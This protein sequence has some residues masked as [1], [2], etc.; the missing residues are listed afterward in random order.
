M[1]IPTEDASVPAPLVEVQR[2]R[3]AWPAPVAYYLVTVFVLI[4]LNFALPRLMPGDAIDG[5]MVSGSPN[6]V[7][8]DETR[9]RLAEY[10]NLDGS[11]LEQYR[12]YLGALAGGD[13]G[14]SIYSNQPVTQ[15]LGDRMGWS[16]L[17]IVTALVASV[18]VGLPLGVHSAWK[19]SRPVDRRLLTFFLTIQNTPVFVVG[20][21]VLNLFSARLGLFPYGGA[22]TYFTDYSGLR[23][24]LDIAHHLALPALVMALDFVAYQ[25]L[26]MRSAMVMELGSDYLLVGRAK[27]LRQR[28]LKYGYAGRNALLPIVTVIGIQLGLSIT[29][30]VFVEGI[31]N[32]PGI[33]GYLVLA[34][35]RRDY[36]A[37]QGAFLILSL[38]VVTANLF[39]DLLYRR[40]D[41]RT[42]A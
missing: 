42:S 33:G 5:L 1:A 39:V 24:V 37:A 40:L 6:F 2:P 14:V 13:L 34:V 12:R 4:T 19:R 10:L 41:P 31:F 35:G 17:L 18:L 15:E 38:M 28:R 11:M 9:A 25:Y 29:T 22:T 7:D 16:L 30:I 26:V 21:F 20:A 36:F 23:Q 32:Y 8:N 3:R 27:G